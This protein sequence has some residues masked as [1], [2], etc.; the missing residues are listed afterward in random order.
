MEKPEIFKSVFVLTVKYNELYGR[1][2]NTAKY[3]EG[4]T[5]FYGI[6]ITVEKLGGLDYKVTTRTHNAGYASKDF[7]FISGILEDL[8]EIHTEEVWGMTTYYNQEQW[9]VY[10]YADF[11]KEFVLIAD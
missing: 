11:Y 2:E 5:N 4:K 1:A 10:R 3:L 7:C 9:S 8:G 6:G